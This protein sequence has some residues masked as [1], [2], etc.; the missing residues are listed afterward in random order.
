MYIFFRFFFFLFFSFFFSP[1]FPFSFFRFLFC[2]F[3]L[4]FV[5]SHCRLFSIS[6]PGQIGVGFLLDWT[7]VGPDWGFY[8]YLGSSPSAWSYDPSTGDIV[9]ATES[10][11]EPAGSLP[12]FQSKEGRI[13]LLFDLPLEAEGTARFV[14]DG[15]TLDATHTIS[16]PPAAVVLPACCLLKRGQKV[17]ITKCEKL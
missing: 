13:G 10:I 7:L 3:V 1:F 8:G 12:K 17:A 6:L 15:V 16:L 2:L 9:S 5:I 4:I 11:T 14:N